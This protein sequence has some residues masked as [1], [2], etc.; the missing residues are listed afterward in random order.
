MV[1]LN[2]RSLEIIIIVVVVMMMVVL[3]QTL[4]I[5]IQIDVMLIIKEWLNSIQ[6]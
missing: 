5:V 6:W 1:V 2:D 3:T 4:N